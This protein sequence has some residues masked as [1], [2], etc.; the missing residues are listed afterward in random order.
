MRTAE[1]KRLPSSSCPKDAVAAMVI[2]TSKIEV[3]NAV[4]PRK[5]ETDGDDSASHDGL[6]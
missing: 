6:S 3:E 4:E 2:K 5:G 1:V